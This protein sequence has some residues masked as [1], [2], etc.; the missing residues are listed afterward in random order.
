VYEADRLTQQ[1]DGAAI[2]YLQQVVQARTPARPHARTHARTHAPPR[3]CP[4]S[5]RPRA[6]QVAP[7][8]SGVTLMLP[9]VCHS[10]A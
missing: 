4:D 10:I 5:V 6:R 3:A 1:L 9:K 7:H 2:R 8:K